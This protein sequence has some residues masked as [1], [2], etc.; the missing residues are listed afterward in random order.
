MLAGQCMVYTRVR[1]VNEGVALAT[2]IA[3]NE[4]TCGFS[5]CDDYLQEF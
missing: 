2:E 1:D 4:K 3:T 5:R